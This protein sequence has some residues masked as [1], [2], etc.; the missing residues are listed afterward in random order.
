MKTAL[1]RALAVGLLIAAGA[2]F[3][4]NLY[5]ANWYVDNAATGSGNGTSW[6][7]AWKNLSSVKWGSGGVQ[8]GDTLYISGGNTAKTYTDLLEVKVAGKP[9]SRITI[10][11]GQ[12]AGHNGT[13]VIEAKGRTDGM[14]LNDYVTL[15]GSVNGQ[16]RMIVRN[17]NAVGIHTRNSQS[18]KGITVTYVELANNGNEASGMKSP[19]FAH[20]IRFVYGE[21]IEISYTEIYGSFKDGI[22]MGGSRGGWGSNRFHHNHIHH[23]GDD[24]VAAGGGVDA[25]N[26]LIHDLTNNDT[27][28]RHPDGF[29]L[30]GNQ[31]RV[32]NNIVY[33]VYNCLIFWDAM[34][35]G[36][37]QKDGII[38]NNLVFQGREF[39][40]GYSRGI[41][42]KP[43]SSAAGLENAIVA[44]NTI[45]NVP[46][47]GIGLSANEGPM[48]NV[49]VVNNIIYNVFTSGKSSAHAIQLTNYSTLSNIQIDYNLIHAGPSGSTR[50]TGASGITVQQHAITGDPKFVKYAPWA[51]DNDYRLQAG[52]AA[53]GAG[54]DLSSIFTTDMNGAVRVKWDVGSIGYSGSVT[55]GNPGDGGIPGN[56]GDGG[57]PGNPGDGGNPGNP[58]DGGNGDVVYG[59][60]KIWLEA[61]GFTFPSP[62][63]TESD[64]AASGNSYL[65]NLVS[66]TQS[67]MP[68]VEGISSRTF[69]VTEEGNYTL[70]MR[71]FT[72]GDAADSIFVKMDDGEWFYWNGIPAG[73]GWTW[74]Q[75]Y[76]S[77]NFNTKASFALEP[78]VHTLYIAHRERNVKLDKMY[79]TNTADAPTGLGGTDAGNGGEQPTQRPSKPRGLRVILDFLQDLFD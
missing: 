12:E 29:Q 9:S 67:A 64:S 2:L 58:G 59:N 55:G 3:S 75:V 8:P 68:P 69:T 38:Y 73:S 37:F 53:I 17:A 18:N 47:Y 50:I 74:A 44:N 63:T 57:N 72:A 11:V 51:L 33:N 27:T 24:G 46:Y 49:R 36:Q 4:S 14:L 35:G 31:V 66:A 42:L 79:I 26:N 77:G 71:A 15:D 23:L 43:E 61:E 39:D 10:R 70:W 40:S 25:W 56:P 13:V 7:N 34:P 65:V 22:N 20:G 60:T 41:Q 32:W 6:A 52:S 21:D 5:A 16:R 54:L 28:G 78:G 76:N 19:G 1:H 30:L 62:T 45:V 48:R